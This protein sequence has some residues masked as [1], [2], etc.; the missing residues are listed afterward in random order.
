MRPRGL[1]QPSAAR[2]I[3]WPGRGSAWNCDRHKVWAAHVAEA[4]GFELQVSPAQVRE[5]DPPP[6]DH[7]A[8]RFAAMEL[9]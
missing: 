4:M 3:H 7:T 2:R 9:D 1:S 5:L 6:P 8:E